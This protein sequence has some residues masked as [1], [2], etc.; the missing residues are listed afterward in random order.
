MHRSDLYG[1]IATKTNHLTPVR[2]LFDYFIDERYPVF[3]GISMR[4]AF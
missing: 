1:F 3:G 4:D 2:P